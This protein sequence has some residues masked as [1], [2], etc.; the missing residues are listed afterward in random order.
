MAK[1]LGDALWSGERAVSRRRFA[2]DHANRMVSIKELNKREMD[3]R[4]PI[5]TESLF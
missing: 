2:L 5:P 4:G 1:I 3:G